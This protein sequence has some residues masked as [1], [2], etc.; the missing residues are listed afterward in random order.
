MLY[1][2]I[3]FLALVRLCRNCVAL[4]CWYY[5]FLSLANKIIELFSFYNEFSDTSV[6]HSPHFDW[7]VAHVGSC[8]PHT[9]ITRVLSCG[10]K[11]FSQHGSADQSVK[12]LYWRKKED[13]VIFMGHDLLCRGSIALV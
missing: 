1:S 7:V 11:D 4:C 3:L 12:V 8:F 2:L 5:D 6:A 13:V 9:V 10:L